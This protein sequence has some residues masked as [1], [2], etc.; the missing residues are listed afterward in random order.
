M[1]CRHQIGDLLHCLFTRTHAAPGEIAAAGEVLPGTGQNYHPGFAFFLDLC[2]RLCQ[3]T[4]HCPVDR[5]LAV[6]TVHCDCENTIIARN[7]NRLHHN[8]DT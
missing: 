5:I 8:D 6:R 3:F 1:N 4:P 2:E 7:L